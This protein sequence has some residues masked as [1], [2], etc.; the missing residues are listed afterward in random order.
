M[1]NSY[2]EKSSYL[3]MRVPPFEPNASASV[4]TLTFPPWVTKS[5]AA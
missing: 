2:L 3:E 4:I 5:T 1:K